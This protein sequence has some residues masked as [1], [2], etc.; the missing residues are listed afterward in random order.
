MT[1]IST[2]TPAAVRVV[3]HPANGL[4]LALTC[5]PPPAG[6]APATVLQPATMPRASA[7]R[8]GAAA[9]HEQRRGMRGLL[10]AP[11]IMPCAARPCHVTRDADTPPKA[12]AALVTVVL[13]LPGAGV[14]PPRPV[15]GVALSGP[16]RPETSFCE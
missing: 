11:L 2:G 15:A 10:S 8:T 16:P 6:L 12:P 1:S 3:P 13:V 7:A 5:A 9:G 4:L 14:D